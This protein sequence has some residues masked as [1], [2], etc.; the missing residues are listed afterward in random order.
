M[1]C[2]TAAQLAA[3][4]GWAREH[5]QH[6]A[7]WHVLAHTGMRRGELL[8][9][10]WR[11]VDLDAGTLSIRRS[12]GMVRNAGESAGVVAGEAGFE[13]NPVNWLLDESG[14]PGLY[15]AF[16]DQPPGGL[17]L[18][19]TAEIEAVDA[20]MTVRIDGG[21]VLADDASYFIMSIDVPGKDLAE[22]EIHEDPPPGWPFREF[23]LPPEL[24]NSHIDSLAFD[25]DDGEE[26]RSDLVGR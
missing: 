1:K 22:C 4:L 10:R 9:L 13:G 21:P 8:A 7:L 12:A 5:S 16:R 25:S 24:A 15:C 17:V 11:D 18:S 6:T 26:V 19:R 23:W 2:W 3:F 14:N 20:G